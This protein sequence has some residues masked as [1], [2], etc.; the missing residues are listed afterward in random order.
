MKKRVDLGKFLNELEK[1]E[2]IEEIKKLHAKFEVVRTYYQID[3]TGDTTPYLEAARKKIHGIFYLKGGKPRRPKASR[4]NKV[5][6][7]F[8]Q[9]SIYKDDLIGLL[10]FRVEATLRFIDDQRYASEQLE[11]STV[12]AFRTAWQ[13]ATDHHLEDKFR[14]YCTELSQLPANRDLR[15][16]LMAVLASVQ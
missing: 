14:Q 8:E 10:L 12:R 3:L 2:L 15:D 16:E 13:L 1:E 5:I 9:L 4:L 11:Q 6:K 7:E